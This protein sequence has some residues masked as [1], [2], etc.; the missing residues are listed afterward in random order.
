MGFGLKDLTSIAR[1]GA[2][3]PNRFISGVRDNGFSGGVDV[4]RDDA[5]GMA[6]QSRS[7]GG[8]G[9][10]EASERLGAIY[11]D[12]WENWKDNYLPRERQLMDLALSDEDNIKAE[13]MA[14]ESTGA[15]FD[16]AALGEQNSLRSLGLQLSPEEMAYRDK[17]RQLNRMGATVDNVNQARLH[18]ADR[19]RNILSGDM[20]GSL[21]DAEQY[22][23]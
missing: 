12:M 1:R 4:L 9:S 6:G 20:T 11:R 15:S 18:A 17:T 22:R 14:R 13:E 8:G 16:A 19:D 10:T 3:S 5:Y 7:N 2:T 23:A 21:R